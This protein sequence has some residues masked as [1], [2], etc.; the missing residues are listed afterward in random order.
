MG[1]DAKGEE[2]PGGP[3]REDP[4]GD[5]AKCKASEAGTGLGNRIPTAD[6]GFQKLCSALIRSMV[7][8]RWETSPPPPGRSGD[9]GL[10]QRSFFL[11]LFSSVTLSLPHHRRRCRWEGK[12]RVKQPPGP[13]QCF[14]SLLQTLHLGASWGSP[15]LCC[16]S[17]RAS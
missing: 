6:F 14:S 8:A 4:P 3:P 9:G 2:E 11:G 17:P 15:E 7:G 13:Q 5:R 10:D 12:L 1:W 16:T